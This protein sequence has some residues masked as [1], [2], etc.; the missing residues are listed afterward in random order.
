MDAAALERKP[1][2]YYVHKWGG[3]F[4]FVVPALLIFCVF[5]IYPFVDI[6]KLSFQQWDGIGPRH[7]VFLQN[8]QELVRNGGWWRSVFNAGYITLI[9]LTFQ[10]MIAFALALACDRE[11]RLKGA[12]RIIFFLPPILSEVVVG[13]LWRLILAPAQQGGVFNKL[14]ANLGL[15]H[16]MNNWLSDPETALTCI[17][18]VHSWKGFGWGFIILLAG[19]QTIDRQFYES[20][21]VDGANYWQCFLNVTI[22]M[23]VPVIL[24]VMILTILGSMQ[25]FILVLSMTPGELS[26]HTD[27]PVLQILTSMQDFKEYGTACA[28]GVIFAGIL[29][30]LSVF[31]KLMSDRIKK[32]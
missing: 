20:A 31:F 5:Y 11:M 32:I 18:I 16:L 14:L 21:R 23:M 3:S 10:N 22:P 8:Y 29:I 13:L 17:A 26:G 24:V 25:S 4:L 12:Y 6:F 2:P 7:W 28:M 30:T 1:F 9:A 27:V 15:H 19:L